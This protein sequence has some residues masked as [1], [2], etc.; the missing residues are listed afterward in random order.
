M[1]R[2]T[3][4]PRTKRPA[5]PRSR[6]RRRVETAALA[7][8]AVVVV[9]VVGAVLIRGRPA[10]PQS[11]PPP[12]PPSL[13]QT[14]APVQPAPRPTTVVTFADGCASAECHGPMGE[15]SHV[16]RTF[17]DGACEE[18][19][20][21]DQGGHVYPQ[22]ASV[23]NA[24]TSC[25]ATGAHHAFQHKAMSDEA[26]LACHDPHASDSPS[27]LVAATVG[28]TCE[29]CHPPDRG[30]VAH[31]PYGAD[32]CAECHDPHG[33]DNQRL[34]LGGPVP[35]NCRLCHAPV[36][37]AVE[38]GAH[39]H[40]AVEGSCLACHDGHAGAAA[41]LLA[42]Q[43]RE[44]CVTCH[45][46]VGAQVSG[47]LV[48]HDA[49]MQGQQ[50]VTCHEPHASGH[51]AMLRDEQRRLC[52]SCHGEPVK[53]ADGRE[54][55]AIG[56]ELAEA[57]LEHGA[58]TIGECSA[59][60]SMHGAQHARL[61]NEIDPRVLPGPFDL[62]NYALCF[63]CHDKGLAD[64]A[65]ATLFRDGDTN[66]HAAHLR[67]GEKSGGCADCHAVHAG[68]RERLV[69]ET[70]RYQGSQW[71]TP[72]NFVITPDGGTCSPGCHEPIAYSRRPGGVAGQPRGGSP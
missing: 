61:L 34:L 52:L 47:A 63:A 27:L 48:S 49:V 62:Q 60:H 39:T 12:A 1:T 38:S 55:K 46:D 42:A 33:A 5:R 19:H 59:C 36:V 40:G 20:G 6:K 22:L 35:E 14:P 72:M 32:R 50:C 29:R 9:G 10:P 7:G 51:H 45:E 69:V 13:V 70:I 15:R 23:E 57:P 30:A 64:M 68:A 25:H 58:V 28:E 53:A 44:L 65:G 66:L 21:A 4:Q 37:L 56:P 43:P 16:H 71:E 26:C 41:G 8:L 17:A 31:E 67:A 2:K 24:C 54:V 3:R 18:C 11:P